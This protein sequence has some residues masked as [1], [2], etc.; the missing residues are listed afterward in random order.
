MSDEHPNIDDPELGRLTRAMTELAD[1]TVLTHDWYVTTHL[2]DGGEIELMVEGTNPSDASRLLPALR[3]TIADLAR[4]R[5]IASD[6]VVTAFSTGEPEQAELDDGASDLALDSIEAS[7]DG[8]VILHFSDDCG[9][10]FPEG[11]WPAVHFA[12]SGAVMQV[13]VES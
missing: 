2:A 10:H 13:T 4:R 1:G 11:Y 7:S 3:E 8:S 5:R 12:P 9:E 6:A